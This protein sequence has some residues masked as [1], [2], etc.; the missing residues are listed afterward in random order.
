MIFEFWVFKWKAILRLRQGK[1]RE[2]ILS[3][4]LYSK[5]QSI[6]D[7]PVWKYQ[8][9]ND[10]WEVKR[11]SMEDY[12]CLKDCLSKSWSEKRDLSWIEERVEV[13]LIF[14][15]LFRIGDDA[16]RRFLYWFL[17]RALFLRFQTIWNEPKSLSDY[18][19]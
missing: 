4:W 14:Q 3:G 7:D 11:E 19:L 12:V 16:G 18:N 8:S 6:C 5:E 15:F 13:H 9:I 1:W 2:T 17:I 10:F